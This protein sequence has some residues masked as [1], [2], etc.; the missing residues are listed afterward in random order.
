MLDRWEEVANQLEELAAKP[1]DQQRQAARALEIDLP[2]EMP[3]PVAAVII[4]HGLA[5]VLMEKAGRQVDI[6]EQLTELESELGVTPTDSLQTGS[7]EELSA[8]FAARY[9]LLTAGGLRKLQPHIGDVVSRADNSENMVISS[10][11]SSGRVYMKGGRGKSAWPNHLSLVSREGEASDYSTLV[12]AVDANLRNNKESHSPS[13]PRLAELE[14]YRITE[15][16]PTTEAVRELEELL[17]SG[18]GNEGPFQK[19]IERHPQLLA[20]LVVGNWGT[21]VIPQKRLGA[22][23]VT[24]FLV[25]G[26]NSLG[27]QWVAVELEAPR[28]ELLTKAGDLR[29]SVLHAMTQINDWRDWLTTNVAYAQT[30]LHLHGLTNQVPGLVVIGRDELRINR[31][32]ARSRVAEQQNIQVHSW[33]WVLRQA[34]HLVEFGRQSAVLAMVAIED[35]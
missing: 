28:H 20:S 9:M 25:L 29:S 14:Q 19:L 8:W 30:E 11:S 21:Y 22:E 34:L 2:E 13:S 12:S 27:P 4:R 23:Y 5:D 6:S 7:S 1:S 3:A 10:I 16:A 32:A 33:D 35:E 17:E 18:E 26:V 15:H 24:D 31:N